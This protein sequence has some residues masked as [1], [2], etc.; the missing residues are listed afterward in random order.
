M[1]EEH[2]IF[3]PCIFYNYSLYSNTANINL[4]ILYA[5]KDGTIEINASQGTFSYAVIMTSLNMQDINN[6]T[7]LLA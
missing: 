5:T 6:R 4:N 2:S 1:T 3:L 7:A